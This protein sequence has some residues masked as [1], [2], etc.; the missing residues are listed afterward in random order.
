[1]PMDGSHEPSAAGPT[2]GY[3]CI[4]IFE[5]S[6][7]NAVIVLTNVSAF[8]ASRGDHISKLGMALHNTIQ[9]RTRHH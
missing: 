2:G 6:T 9:Y 5:R 3:S 1:M 8:L 7:R 4:V